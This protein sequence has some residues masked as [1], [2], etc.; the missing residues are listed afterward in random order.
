[1]KLIVEVPRDMY[2]DAKNGKDIGE[3]KYITE[4]IKRGSPCLEDGDTVSR[5]HIYDELMAHQLSKDF[6]SEHHI[7]YSIDSG[8]ARIIVNSAPSVERHG[9]W[10]K[11]S[12]YGNSWVDYGFKFRCSLC[13]REQIYSSNYCSF[14][15]AKM[16]EV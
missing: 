9:E 2:E 1:M 12:I 6:C 8:M 16:K 10:T 13:E 4:V 7:D 3:S 14:C 5:K 11:G 15:G